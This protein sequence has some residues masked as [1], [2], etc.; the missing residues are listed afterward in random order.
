M[1]NMRLIAVLSL[2]AVL[3]LGSPAARAAGCTCSPEPFRNRWNAVDAVFTAHVVGIKELH[4][5]IRKGNAND[6]P[7]SVLLKVTERFKGPDT[8]KKDSGFE[9]LTSLTRDTCTGHP[10]EEGKDYLVWAYKRQEEKFDATSL[11]NMPAGSY[12]VGGLCGGTKA[13][14]E[15]EAVKEVA[16]IREKLAEEPEE[17]P[18]GLFDRMFGN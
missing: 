4:Q 2:L 7:V 15:A 16:V 1:H 12:D 18:S 5:Y 3:M 11:Y 9:L 10:F 14:S 6:I 8:V 17:K 13:M